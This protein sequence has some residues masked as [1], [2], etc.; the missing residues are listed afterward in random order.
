[1]TVTTYS[2]TWGFWDKLLGV[3]TRNYV[4]ASV[5]ASTTTTV[6][7]CPSGKKAYV[8]AIATNTSPHNWAANLNVKDSGGTL[9]F[10][11]TFWTQNV[12][13]T[14]SRVTTG[15][16]QVVQLLELQAGD[17]IEIANINSSTSFNISLLIY[18][19]SA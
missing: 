18:E 3:G 8:V 11:V 6:Y 12:G 14:N 16:N 10:S 19:V 2:D 1:M 9:M 4:Y 17:Y 15:I 5:G 13:D 7:T